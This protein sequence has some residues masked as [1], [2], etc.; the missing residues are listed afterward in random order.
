MK[1]RKGERER[2]E[3]RREASEQAKARSSLQRLVSR[4]HFQKKI[5]KKAM[6]EPAAASPAPPP[7]DDDDRGVQPG[8]PHP[9]GIRPWGA[10]LLSSG[11]ERGGGDGDRDGSG[12]GDGVDDADASRTTKKPRRASSSSCSASRSDPR[13][14]LGALRRLPDEALLLIVASLPA[15]DLAAI[16]CTSRALY[17]FAFTAADGGVEEEEDEGE[18]GEEVDEEEEDNDKGKKE[19]ARKQRKRRSGIGGWRS[20]TLS[21]FGGAWAWGGTWARTY[22]AAAWARKERKERKG[23]NDDETPPPHASLVAACER[24]LARRLPP[25]P[26]KIHVPLFSDALY[27]TWAATAADPEPWLARD[28]LPRVDASTL[29]PEEFARRFDGPA[30]PVVLVGAAR[31]WPAFAKWQSDEYLMNVLSGDAAGAAGSVNGDGGGAEKE[32][33]RTETV[34]VGGVEV[35]WKHFAAYAATN[36]D[37]LPLTVFDSKVL[38]RIKELREDLGEGAPECLPVA[39]EDEEEEEEEEEEENGDDEK[40][41]KKT[42]PPRRRRRRRERDLFSVLPIH[43]RPDHEWLIAGGRRSGSGFHI[44]PNATSAWNAV[45]RGS[46]KWCLYPPGFPPPGVEPSADL[47]MVTAPAALADWFRGFYEEAFGGG[48]GCGG[49][50]EGEDEEEKGNGKQQR[51]GGRQQQHHRL[52]TAAP[53]PFTPRYRPL[54]GIVSAGDT[55]FVPR[56]WWHAVL[57]L[58]TPTIA[59]TTNF[60]SEAGLPQALRWVRSRDASLVSGVRGDEARLRLAQ[61]WEVALKEKAPETLAEAEAKI[62]REDAAVEARRAKE[63]ALASLFREESGGG[64]RKKKRE[65]EGE[66]GEAAAVGAPSSAPGG[67]FSFNFAVED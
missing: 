2:E 53:L 42:A 37:D 32:G 23:R 50:G 25:S 54:E 19:E 58:E 63:R 59:V 27:A 3:E 26:P 43:L 49:G 67:G 9:L 52:L 29:T 20:A 36:A 38:S 14:G 65:G 60:V 48:A 6:E 21:A 66:E 16:S 30:L 7:C 57:N 34:H 45:V 8:D 44:D 31:H 51:G 17:A 56:G 33:K 4:R 10:L 64:E 22:A 5:K 1:K 55:I 61:R 15:R 18:E 13:L 28:T 39:R 46:K 35:S 24:A 11:E 62:E 40:K 12:G 47:S 41:N